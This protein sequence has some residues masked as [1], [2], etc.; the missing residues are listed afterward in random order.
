M[1]ESRI[2]YIESILFKEPARIL[3]EALRSTLP[4]KDRFTIK[5]ENDMR[6]GEVRIDHWLLHA[7]VNSVLSRYSTEIIV[8]KSLMKCIR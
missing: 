1:N 4:L 7:K 8:G 6:Y 5:L 3:R 2:I